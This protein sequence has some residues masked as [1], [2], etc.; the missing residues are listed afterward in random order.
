MRRIA[1]AALAALCL[2]GTAL[3]AA[4]KPF[5][6]KAPETIAQVIARMTVAL[7]TEGCSAELKALYYS[8]FGAIP[9]AGCT[10][11]RNQLGTFAKPEGKIYGTG[12]VVDALTG[13]SDDL[14][15]AV[16]V[17][18]KGKFRIV[19]V[20]PGGFLRD[21]ITLFQPPFDTSFRIGVHALRTG[22][23]DEFMQVAH[24][25]LGIGAGAQADVCSRVQSNTLHKL[26]AAEP[27]AVAKRLG[28]SS[29]YAFYGIRFKTGFYTVVMAQQPPSVKIPKQAQYAFVGGY[30]SG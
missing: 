19:F 9:A 2:C 26:L 7:K 20:E 6:P 5:A 21:A 30:P 16:M 18:D 25:R 27:R 14:A 29:G 8:G 1:V 28:G 23:C 24:Q 4:P 3:S 12:A 11:L 17:L 15:A 22:N 10:Y 13:H